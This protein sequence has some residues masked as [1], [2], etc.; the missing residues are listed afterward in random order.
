[1]KGKE[2]KK[3]IGVVIPYPK[4][5]LLQHN[6]H[7]IPIQGGKTFQRQYNLFQRKSHRKLYVNESFEDIEVRGGRSQ[8]KQSIGVSEVLEIFQ[9]AKRIEH[10]L[11]QFIVTSQ[12]TP[13]RTP[14]NP[15]EHCHCLQQHLATDSS[16]IQ[17]PPCPAIP[18]SHHLLLL[19]LL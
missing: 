6:G 3:S 2:P 8:K 11:N 15:F 1:M 10:K 12:T 7:F 9:E 19:L 13:H 4:F 18:L 16:R 14:W 17:S 5:R